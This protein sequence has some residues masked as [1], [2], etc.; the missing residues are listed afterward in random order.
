MRRFVLYLLVAS[1]SP[2]PQTEPRLADNPIPAPPPPATQATG[3][4][5]PEASP[6]PATVQS[7][8]V[9]PPLS[10]PN[11]TAKPGE[12]TPPPSDAGASGDARTEAL[13]RIGTIG[14]RCHEKN[15]PDV[16]G[17]FSLQ[18]ALE[19]DG[20]IGKVRAIEAKSTKALVGGNFER[21]LVEGV[22]KERFPPPGGEDVVLEV[23]LSF[24]PAK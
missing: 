20:S 2:Q 5:E 9:V 18:I 8:K 16:A 21:C 23:P 3:D 14:Q 1:C 12:P 11:A 17:S 24:K 19:S 10:S 7:A 13:R 6:P 22:K 15:T 4:G